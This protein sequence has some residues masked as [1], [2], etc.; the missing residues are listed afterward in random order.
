M[1]KKPEK[2]SKPKVLATVAPDVRLLGDI[3]SLIEAGREQVAQAVNAGLVLLYWSVGERIRR[4]ILGNKRAEY[5]EEILPTLSAKLVVEYG[6]GFSPRN[7]ARMIRFA[8]VLPEHAIVSTLSRQLGWSHFVEILGMDDPL[9][10]DFYAEMCRIERWSVRTLRAKIGGMLFERTALSKKPKLLVEHE[11]AKLR[12]EDQLS[13]DLVF[14]DPYFLDFLGLKGKYSEKDLESAILAEMEAFILELG[15]GFAFVARQKRI[16]I[17]GDDHYI[18]LL[19]YHRNLRRLVVIELKLEKFQ[20][21]HKGQMELYLRWLNKHEKQPG[22]EAPIG[23]IL[24]EK[25]GGET[26]E[27]LELD[28]SSIRVA[29]YLTQLPSRELL[30]QKLHKA[31]ELARNRLE[32]EKPSEQK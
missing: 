4:E 31:A 16:I 2:V 25:A 24:C 15:V 17:D 18:D 30:Q 28:A 6:Q 27:L 19:F 11:L 10:R 22:E 20:A 3:R 21:A 13:P 7:L 32:A 14:R 1:K 5:G 8:E 29:S 26:V 12:K 9:K 23:L